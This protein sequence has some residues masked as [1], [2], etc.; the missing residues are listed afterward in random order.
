MPKYNTVRGY[1][2]IINWIIIQLLIEFKHN[3]LQMI[4]DADDNC[5]VI[6]VCWWLSTQIIIT[7]LQGHWNDCNGHWMTGLTLITEW[8]VV[9]QSLSL[10]TEGQKVCK[11]SAELLVCCTCSLQHLQT[12]TSLSSAAVCGHCLY[13]QQSRTSAS[14]EGIA[15]SAQKRKS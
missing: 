1:P 14:Y 11:L 4:T 10:Y 2:I 8:V 7:W 15:D 13:F 3:V 12:A 5:D 9:K 6:I